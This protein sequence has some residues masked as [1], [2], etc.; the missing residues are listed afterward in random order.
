M[1]NGDSLKA[2]TSWL[3]RTW[4]E[5]RREL[6]RKGAWSGYLLGF[7]L[8]GFFD[9]ILLHQILQW[10]HLLLGVQ[11]PP[12]QNMRAQILAD[13]VFHA[14]MYVIAL[15]G[16]WSLWRG[17]E[18]ADLMAGRKLLSHALIGFGIWHVLDALLSHW[19]LGIHRI[20]MNSPNPLLWDLLWFALFGIVP[21]IA[22]VLLGRSHD[23]R[24][25]HAGRTA[26][27]ALTLAVIVGGPLAAWPPSSSDQVLVVVRPSQASQL[28]D[29][30]D[31]LAGSIMW[32]DRSAAIWVISIG[33]HAQARQLYRHGALVVTR[34]PAMLG[35]LAWTRSRASET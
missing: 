5:Q 12:F 25:A 21:I 7:A 34:S 2:E 15:A 19:L 26:T 32:A 24:V 31:E 1:A 28:L 33:E 30:L 3:E 17:R 11:S 13:G 14:L 20:K 16:L 23:R 8:S 27:T 29:G 35:C 18:S 6:A 9:G 10:H 4:R 22:G